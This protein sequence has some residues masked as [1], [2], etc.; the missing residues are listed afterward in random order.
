[1][2]RYF[3]SVSI[4]LL[5]AVRC[6]NAQPQDRPVI[7]ESYYKIKGGLTAEWLELYKKN[8]LSILK[9]LQKEGIIESIE[10]YEIS[11]HRDVGGYN[12]KAVLRLKN[13]SALDEMNRR[14]DKVREKLFPDKA[15][16]D[17]EEARRWEIT[18]HHWDDVVRPVQIP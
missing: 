5:L 8:H 14:F 12:Y 9:E 17:K 7:E 15:A 1:M 3:I 2:L 16:F 4:M 18:E 13:W 6:A 10:L 11:Y